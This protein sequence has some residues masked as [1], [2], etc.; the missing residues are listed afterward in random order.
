M[1]RVAAARPRPRVLLGKR[2]G[3]SSW[4]RVFRTPDALEVEEAEGYDVSRRRVWLD[5]VLLVTSHRGYGPGFLIAMAVLT[6]MFGLMSLGI[7]IADRTAG[8]VSLL[9]FVLPFAAAFG[10][11]LALGLDVVTVHG[12]RTRAEMHFWFRKARGR[13]VFQDVCRLARER[14][15][16]LRAAQ[17]PRP[18]APSPPW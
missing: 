2:S 11:R 1:A 18:P 17:R 12:R 8:L 15:D 10:L 13:Q 5:E 4:E 3:L 7:L 16:A 9:L 14:Q 6:T